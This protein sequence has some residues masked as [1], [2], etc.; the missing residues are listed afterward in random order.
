MPAGYLHPKF[1]ILGCPPT[2]L[3][4]GKLGTQK[5]GVFLLGRYSCKFDQIWYV[6]F[7]GDVP[8]TPFTDQQEIWHGRDET[9]MLFYIKL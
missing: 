1:W 8:I 6:K 9:D 4:K 7:G 3:L 5:H 2:P